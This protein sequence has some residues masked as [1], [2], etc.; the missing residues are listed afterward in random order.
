MKFI[1]AKKESW[2]AFIMN[3]F[4]KFDYYLFVEII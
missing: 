1:L 2:I 4:Y 3:C